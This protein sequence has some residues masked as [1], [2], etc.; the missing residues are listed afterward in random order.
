M[1]EREARIFMALADTNRRRL[2]S[3]LARRSPQTATQLARKFSISRQGIMKHLDLL[4][5]AGLV[6]AQIKG[7]EKRYLLNPGSLRAASDWIDALGRQWD[8]RLLRLKAL[9]EEEEAPGSGDVK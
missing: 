8:K 3:T 4:S 6:R 1:P 2:L 7:R 9:V 5:Q